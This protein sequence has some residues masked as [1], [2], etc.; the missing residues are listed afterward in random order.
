M[1]K[2][3]LPIRGDGTGG[4]MRA[5]LVI[6]ATSGILLIGCASLS[7]HPADSGGITAA[8]VGTRIVLGVTTLGI[9]EIAIAANRQE[10]DRERYL[11]SLWDARDRALLRVERADTPLELEKSRLALQA[12]EREI[13]RMT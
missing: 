6:A 11:Q 9:S 8:K 2:R 1:E 12:A 7:L 10:A 3:R 4:S 5:A 13:E